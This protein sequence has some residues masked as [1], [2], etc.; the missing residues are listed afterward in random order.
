M[1]KIIFAGVTVLLALFLV[2]CDDWLN[3]PVKE[4]VE[5]IEYMDWQYEGL[6]DGR[7]LLTLTLD[8]SK[9]FAHVKQNQRALSLDLAK[10]SHDYFEA[11]FVSPPG[12]GTGATITISRAAWEIGMSAGI[13]GVKRDVNY[14]GLTVGAATGTNGSAIIFVG[15]KAG[16]TLLGVGHIVR[17]DSDWDTAVVTSSTK[18]V[19]FG[20]YPL[21]TFVGVGFP[22]DYPD[23]GDLAD[24]DAIRPTFYTAPGGT[25][26]DATTTK[27]EN[28]PLQKDVEYPQFELPEVD[29]EAFSSANPPKTDA[30]YTI[31]G[32]GAGDTSS[33][34]PPGVT[35]AK[36]DYHPALI[37]ADK[38]EIIKRT[39]LF[40]Y[41]GQ[42][43]EAITDV[44]DTYTKVDA[45]NNQ[46]FG[47]ATPETFQNPISMTFTQSIQ[48]AGIFAITFQVPVYA[49]TRAPLL[50]GEPDNS[51]NGGPPAT[52]WYIRPGYNQYQFLLDDGIAAGGAVL[53]GTGTGGVDWLEIFTVGIGFSN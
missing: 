19:T 8:G 23:E 11:V 10:M 30:I 21:T 47:S 17:A 28:V 22:A 43:Y 27:V 9:P 5:E 50:A 7:G 16:K 52:K 46:T 31:G 1:K 18:S 53:L 35:L 44:L 4:D 49:I 48:S 3:L 26:P 39:P 29:V 42:T 36:P 24:D 34:I 2:T 38:L 25:T 33:G 13:S 14:S 6:P 20:V 51:D 45:T 40:L 15:K 32:L 12:S 41:K 37:L